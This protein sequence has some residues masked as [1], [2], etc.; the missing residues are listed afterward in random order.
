MTTQ[1][2]SDER[3]PADRSWRNSIATVCISGTLEDKVDAAAAAGFDGIEIVEPD[4]IA[5][6]W[7][8]AQV[9]VRCA[10]VGLTIDLYQPFRDFDSTDPERVTR[11]LRRAQKK[12]DV[13]EQLGTDLVLLC[14]NAAPDAVRDDARLAE[15]LALLAGAAQDR[16]MRVCY[17]ALAWGTHVNTYDHSWRIVADIDHPSLGLCLDSFHILSRG[18]DPAGIA[19][20]PAEKLF[21]LQLADAPYM[22]MNVLQWSRHHRLFPGQGTFDLPAFL[23]HVIDAG[24]TGPLSLEVFNDVFRQAKPQRAAVDALRSL[25]LLQEQALGRLPTGPREQID[26]RPAPASPRLAGYAFVEL[27]V[28]DESGPAV[29]NALAALGFAHTGRHRTKP[30]QLWQQGSARILLNAGSG[31]DGPRHQHGAAVAAIGIETPDPTAAADRAQAL[32]APLLPRS[33]GP[34]EADLAAVAAPD[35]T[36]VFFCRPDAGAADSWLAD[37]PGAADGAA[38]TADPDP[39]S[40]GL[41]GID[42]IA[43]TQPYDRFDEAALFYRSVLGMHTQANGEIAA[44]YGLV[45][46]RVVADPTGR[47]RV[48]LSVSVLRRGGDWLPGVVEPQHVAFRTS[49]ALAA[50][51][52]AMDAGAPLLRVPDNYYDDLDARLALPAAQLARMRELG[53]LYDQGPD[54]EYL[55]FY[56]EVLGG[57][58]FLEV[59]QR[60]GAYADFGESNGPVRMA[61]HR[62]QRGSRRDRVATEPGSADTDR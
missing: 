28:G 12:F 39:E 56:T 24:Y 19:Q 11:N 21:F 35:G 52:A 57:R 32:L 4:F 41:D 9:R 8:A 49:D 36:Q 40:G 61:A 3:A 23:T 15:Q 14:S 46:N 51:A 13:M 31:S 48:C 33:R 50:A 7:S 1:T 37:F 30:V 62:A 55:H 44:P 43:L 53:V 20:I 47:V 5:S 27:A 58:V 18:S 26:I 45:R 2:R 54:G 29:A 17:E 16:G 22:D 6:P 25:L 10:A 60:I 38:P 59:V 34:A 42:H